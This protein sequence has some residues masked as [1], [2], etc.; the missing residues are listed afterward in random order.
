MLWFTFWALCLH[1][2]WSPS[3]HLTV[4]T[5][6][7]QTFLSQVEPKP[8][9]QESGLPDF[10]QCNIPKGEENIPNNHKMHQMAIRYTYHLDVK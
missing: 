6:R 5:E 8:N 7:V 4:E 10:S 3:K 1:R 2:I 9:E